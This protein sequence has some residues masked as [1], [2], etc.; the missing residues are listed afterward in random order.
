[1]AQEPLR[2]N[3]K[4]DETDVARFWTTSSTLPPA[5]HR[6]RLDG[7]APTSRRSGAVENQIHPPRPDTPTCKPA[8]RYQQKQV[9]PGDGNW[10]NTPPRLESELAMESGGPT[11]ILLNVVSSKHTAVRGI[12]ALHA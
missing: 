2:R 9:A 6:G 8:A 1:M 12:Q 7:R 5:D 3:T 10:E 11:F 4:K